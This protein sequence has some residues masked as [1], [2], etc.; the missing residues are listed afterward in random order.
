MGSIGPIFL[1]AK[2]NLWVNCDLILRGSRFLFYNHEIFS[3][4]LLFPEHRQADISVKAGV[5]DPFEY[6]PT[7]NIL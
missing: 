5:G 4:D 7:E 3:G 6:L 2:R 1:V